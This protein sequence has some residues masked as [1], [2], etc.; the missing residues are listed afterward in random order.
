MILRFTS[1][2]FALAWGIAFL[3]CWS[4]CIA[5]PARATSVT[6]QIANWEEV[7]QV[8]ARH[9]GR[10]VLVDVWST[11]C[12]P[13]VREFPHL[14]KLA[15]LYRDDVVC[16][17]AS[18]DYAGIKSKPVE[19]YRD[20]V[21]QF[22]TKQKAA[23]TTNFLLSVSADALLESLDLDSIPAVYVYGRDGK[24]LQ[25]FDNRYHSPHA[26]AAP[27]AGGDSTDEAVEPEAFTYQRDVVPFV[28]TLL[29]K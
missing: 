6:V 24:L 22:L 28:E 1:T 13:C 18:C 25:R 12:E 16:L 15:E 20:R 3:C 8:V 5:D 14:V 10:V 21:E 4:D 9:T 23:S 27:P 17:S 19:Y 29:K 26:K 2:V 11:T 7:Q